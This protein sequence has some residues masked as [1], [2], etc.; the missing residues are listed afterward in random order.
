MHPL[1]Y[2]S[3][4]TRHG[5]V[6]DIKSDIGAK[7]TIRLPLPQTIEFDGISIGIGC[8]ISLIAIKLQQ[9]IALEIARVLGANADLHALDCQ[10]D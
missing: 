8:W 3:V 1:P 7:E 6:H 9:S 10:L 4:N 2:G 5:R